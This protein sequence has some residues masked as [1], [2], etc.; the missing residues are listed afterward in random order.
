[1]ASL[2]L[3]YW[4]GILE[5][6][7][8]LIRYPA[9]LTNSDLFSTLYWQ[10]SNRNFHAVDQSNCKVPFSRHIDIDIESLEGT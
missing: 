4:V 3:V 8:A 1:M 5:A 10:Q 9:A 2:H 6:F 7:S